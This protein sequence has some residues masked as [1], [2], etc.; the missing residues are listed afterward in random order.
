MV[1]RVYACNCKK[2]LSETSI[3]SALI[4]ADVH[5]PTKSVSAPAAISAV[6]IFHVLFMARQY[7]GPTAQS[8]QDDH[9]HVGVIQATPS[10]NTPDWCAEQVRTRL[11]CD[12]NVVL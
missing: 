1:L 5:A 9:R 7:A 6:L 12:L 2:K 8:Y 4:R 11:Q 10:I 3:I